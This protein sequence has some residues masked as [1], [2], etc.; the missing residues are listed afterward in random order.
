MIPVRT[1]YVQNREEEDKKEFE[2][3]KNVKNKFF[4]AALVLFLPL[5]PYISKSTYNFEKNITHPSRSVR[6][7]PVLKK[8][9]NL[10]VNPRNG[11]L[12][13]TQKTTSVL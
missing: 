6:G 9:N 13:K 4:I 8:E 11:T 3:K 10:A 5:C 2:L 7:A 12:T 1:Y